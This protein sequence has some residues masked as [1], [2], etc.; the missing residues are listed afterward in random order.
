[1]MRTMYWFRSRHRPID[2]IAEL[3]KSGDPPHTMPQANPHHFPILC[4]FSIATP[5][6]NNE[7]STAY[8]NIRNSRYTFFIVR[9]NTHP[10]LAMSGTTARPAAPSRWIHIIHRIA[11]SGKGRK[12]RSN[13]GQSK[14]TETLSLVSFSTSC[15][16]Q[17]SHSILSS[18]PVVVMQCRWSVVIE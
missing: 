16:I 8:E 15:S 5:T 2:T 4:H 14:H 11:V 13:E 1:M 18:V 6:S 10:F 12:Q 9:Q 17:W 3:E 7:H